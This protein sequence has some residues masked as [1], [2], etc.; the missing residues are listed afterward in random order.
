MHCCTRITEPRDTISQTKLPERHFP[1]VGPEHFTGT[2][3]TPLGVVAQQEQGEWPLVVAPPANFQPVVRHRE[4]SGRVGHNAPAN[5]SA[6]EAKRKDAEVA[7]EDAEG[8]VG[9]MGFQPVV[10]HREHSGRVGHNA[11]ANGSANEAK[12]KDAEV[13]EEDA[14]SS[15]SPS[16]SV[17]FLK[18][19]LKI[20]SKCD[21]APP[22]WD[23]C[24]FVELA[25]YI[26]HPFV[27]FPPPKFWRGG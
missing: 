4:H 17:T 14:I 18:K 13:A 5:G 3:A 2:E 22:P 24:G 21:S 15:P 10:R 9:R 11:P 26:L 23:F 19:H 27:T 12:R 1:R 8:M 6:N 20:G 16:C 7:E 25:L